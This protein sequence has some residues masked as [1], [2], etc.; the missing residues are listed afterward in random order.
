MLAP[1]AKAGKSGSGIRDGSA[2]R[3]LSPTHSSD[4]DSLLMSRR[5]CPLAANGTLSPVS[6][7]R[8]TCFLSRGRRPVAVIATAI[9]F[10]LKPLSFF[11]RR[12]LHGESVD[13]TRRLA[14]G[15]GLDHRKPSGA[16]LSASMM[17]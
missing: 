16:A 14:C 13:R 17:R 12:R 10:L 7:S 5:F 3:A 11:L 1:T 6:P 8:T 15:R 2:S 4:L 9:V